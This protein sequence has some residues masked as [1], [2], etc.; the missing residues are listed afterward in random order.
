MKADIGVK[1]GRIVGI[2]KAGNPDV[3]TGVNPALLVGSNT[4]AIAGEGKI[5]TAGGI[6]THC[7]FIC[8]Q[9]AEEALTSGITTQFSGGTGPR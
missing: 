1:N 8:P 9:Q 3:M 4:D 2:G 7:H 5:I 6:D